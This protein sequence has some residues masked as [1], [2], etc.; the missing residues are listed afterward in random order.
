MH[1]SSYV[2][3]GAEV[4][5]GTKIWYFSHISKN[6]KI[7]KN[8]NLGQN[9]F[10]G[11]NVIIGDNVKLQNNV[12]I[13]DGVIL[14]N[15]VF[16]GPSCVFTNVKN[17]RSFID[18]KHEFKKTIVRHGATIGANATIVCGV[19]IGEYAFIGTG[20][21]V[22]KDVVPYSLVI[23]IPAKFTGFVNKKGNKIP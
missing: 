9:V 20:A 14:E 18:R 22:T 1:E 23:G 19:I 2:D 6:S 13:Y 4:G 17:P 5:K 21:V 3:S 7:G 12:S 15:D 8:C 11:S 16:C 10:I